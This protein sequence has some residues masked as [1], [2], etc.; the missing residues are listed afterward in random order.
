MDHARNTMLSLMY[1]IAIV[2][3]FAAI[4]EL[5]RH[6]PVYLLSVMALVWIADIGA[7]F[8]GK[9]FGKHKLAP[10]IS[11]GKSWEGAVGGW[12]AVLLLAAGTTAIPAM[13]DTFAVK[14][15]AKA[16]WLWFFGAMTLMVAASIAGDLFES[17]L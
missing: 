6:S 12:L 2:G 10:S 13:G 8:A 5:F 7:Y 15:Q 14:L 17:Q 9:A 4:V 16:G 1:A 11:P 3:C